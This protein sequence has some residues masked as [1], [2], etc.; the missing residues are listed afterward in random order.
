MKKFIF[1]W[2]LDGILIDLYVLIME[3]F[4]EIYC[5]FG[6]IFDKELIYEY[7]L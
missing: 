1:I 6:L 5:Y 4:E 2:D 7:I 3:V